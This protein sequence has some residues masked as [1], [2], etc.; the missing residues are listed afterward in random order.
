MKTLNQTLLVIGNC[1]KFTP[2]IDAQLAKMWNYATTRPR[3]EN[4]A[5][6]EV[7]GVMRICWV[8]ECEFAHLKILIRACLRHNRELTAHEHNIEPAALYLVN[9]YER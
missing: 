6:V 5:P 2:R 7:Q 1:A 4:D 9:N 3:L 8:S